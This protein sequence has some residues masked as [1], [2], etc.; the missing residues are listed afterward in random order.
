MARD[1]VGEVTSREKGAQPSITCPLCGR[2][3]HH[4]KD[5]EE[6]YCGACHWWTGRTDMLAA[7]LETWVS[8]YSEQRKVPEGCALHPAVLDALVL[9]LQRR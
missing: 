1:R 3:S 4:P 2:T 8:E 7:R 9:M 6:G 5:I